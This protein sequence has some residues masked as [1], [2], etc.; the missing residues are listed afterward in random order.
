MQFPRQVQIKMS[1]LTKIR[2]AN[3]GLWLA[4]LLLGVIGVASYYSLTWLLK[5]KELVE[6]TYVVLRQIDDVSV[7]LKDAE[8]GR[9]GY[10]ITRDANFL[11]TYKLGV[12]ETYQGIGRL[13]QS[14]AENP[15]QQQHLRQ[16]QPLLDQ[17]LASMQQSITLWQ[18]DPND[19]ETQVA[20][21]AAGGDLQQQLQDVLNAMEAEE[22]LL[23]QQRQLAAQLNV[24]DMV[25]SLGTGYVVSFGL[26]IAAYS[27][28]QKNIRDRQQ[29]ENSLREKQH[30]IEQVANAV[31]NLLY[32][33]DRSKQRHIYINHC[34]TKLLGG[35]LEGFLEQ[36]GDRLLKLI[37]PDDMERI[38]AQRQQIT[39]MED[40]DVL[41]MDYRMKT[42]DGSWHWFNV[43]EVIFSRASQH[44]PQ[45]VLGIAQ[46]ITERKQ[47]S[48]ALQQAN[49]KLTGW[50]DELQQRNDEI[51]LLSHMSDLLQV[52]LTLE[53]AYEVMTKVLPCLFPNSS[54]G[55]F[56]I[57]ESR[58]LVEAV[59]VWGSDFNSQMLFT[60]QDCIAL[61]R[62]QPYLAGH[63]LA[64]HG[65][66]SLGCRHFHPPLS[67]ATFCIPLVAHGET[68]GLL[69]LSFVEP[70]QQNQQQL[71]ITV[72]RQI[73]LAMANLK[74][75]ETLQ[76][77]SIRDAL[78][79]LF[80][81]RY[82]EESLPREI[83]RAL[84]KQQTLGIIMLDIDNFKRFNDTFGHEAGDIVLQ[85]VGLF[86][87]TN[88]RES[89]IACRYGGEELTLV[90]PE[91]SL[92]DTLQ[93]AEQIR[94]GIEHLNVQ[95]RHQSLGRITASLGVACFPE[96]DLTGE[97]IIKAADA[98][99]YR[100]KAQ[101]R[102]RV[103]V[104]G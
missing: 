88:T 66:S 86:L 77:Q 36:S 47:I 23:L 32:I 64:G 46:D 30:F 90:L 63:N 41:E 98:A 40:S 52:C 69:Y 65:G 33:Y 14:V 93:R 45:Q 96:H 101:G 37:H 71:A 62:G 26:L 27:L 21:T 60:P 29:V 19:F 59:A 25:I 91:A 7:G 20:I 104:A 10:I 94:T 50:V 76:H 79:G 38:T 17:K 53:E 5:S 3:G 34:A 12:Q 49:E 16:L 44:E 31:P 8:R 67:Q 9:R 103:V 13:E 54:G 42:A 55:I 39:A 89:D 70:L 6:R 102:N 81:R 22:Q 74:L 92:L 68:M 73:G 57:S 83:Q 80:N 1:G 11:E 97:G 84:R 24:R 56:T 61:R 18:Q 85:E 43:R 28:L 51:T 95:H 4:L 58:N 100:A 72:S 15:R 35:D 75:R 87:R 99:L 82:L 2:V 78:T 48:E